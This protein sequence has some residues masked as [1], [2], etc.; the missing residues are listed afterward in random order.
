MKQLTDSMIEKALNN[1]VYVT[2]N[3]W[4]IIAIT[5]AVILFLILIFFVSRNTR[6]KIASAL[7]AV[8]L[9]IMCCVGVGKN[10]DVETS[11]KNGEW[12]VRTDIVDR[13]MEETHRNG[14]KDYFMVLEKYGYVSLD[15]YSEA[16]QYY[17]GAKVYVVVVPKGGDYK[18]TGV[19]YPTD[20][21]VYVG[22]H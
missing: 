2:E 20:T 19:T 5:G 7:L 18:S 21:Y 1:T 13:V 17:S 16:I 22:S 3:P 12:I 8:M 6:Q 14:N 11:I 15:S 4:T 9:F 10:A